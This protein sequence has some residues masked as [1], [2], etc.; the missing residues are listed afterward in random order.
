MERSEAR[1][2]AVCL[3]AAHN[4][5]QNTVLN[6]RGY[7]AGNLLM[8]GVLIGITGVSGVAPSEMGLSLRLERRALR[9]AAI[10]SALVLGGS[11]SALAHPRSRKLLR[12]ERSRDS[13]SG[14]IAYKS[15]VR[16]PI[17]TALFEEATFRGVLPALTGRSNAEGDLLAAGIFGLWHVIPTARALAGSP[18][19][20]DMT[21]ADR[22]I[23]VMAGCAATMAAGLGL[24]W[25]RRC[26]RSLVLPW[27]VHSAF[28][29][30]TYLA[31]VLAWRLSDRRS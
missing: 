18:L 9:T 20:R 24:S 19:S 26:S 27:L 10:I 5:T 11:A 4:I 30:I 15:L 14:V 7:V 25:L 31:G 12:D 16:F 22:A 13:S 2:V 17:G 23:A 29:T 21:L 8:S 3:I 28:N 6:Q 1:R